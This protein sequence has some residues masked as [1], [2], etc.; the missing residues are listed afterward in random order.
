MSQ[1]NLKRI[2]DWIEIW[3]C[4]DLVN[5]ILPFRPV[6]IFLHD[7]VQSMNVWCAEEFSNQ[8]ILP[9]EREQLQ[10]H[11]HTANAR[12]FHARMCCAIVAT[13]EYWLMWL[14][15]AEHALL[16]I[17]HWCYCFCWWILLWGK[18]VLKFEIYIRLENDINIYRASTMREDQLSR[19]L[20]IENCSTG[21][22]MDS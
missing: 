7:E 4:F 22:L 11:C 14:K 3:R 19:L 17:T 5:G 13:D 2:G 9:W 20:W 15:A 18:F 6:D 16:L 8:C 1:H 21:Y 12:S 10:L